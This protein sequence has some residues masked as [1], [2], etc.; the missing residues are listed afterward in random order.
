MYKRQ[1]Q[2]GIG[3]LRGGYEYGRSGNPTRTALETQIAALEGGARA[4]SFASGLAAEDALLRAALVPG[5][6]VLLGNDVY[7]GPIACSRGC[8][9]RGA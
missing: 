2:D 3:G 1:A 4:L 5:D 7:G 9:V 6:E 8:W